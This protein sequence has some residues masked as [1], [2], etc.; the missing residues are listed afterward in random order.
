MRPFSRRARRLAVAG[1]GLAALAAGALPV[2]L[3]GHDHRPAAFDAKAAGSLTTSPEDNLAPGDPSIPDTSPAPTATTTTARPTTTTAR[4]TTTSSTTTTPTGAL[5]ACGPG[6]LKAQAWTDRAAYRPGDTVTVTAEL[7]NVSNRPCLFT[8]VDTTEPSAG[9]A[10]TVSFV[11]TI[12]TDTAHDVISL[13]T[14][15]PA[16]CGADPIALLPG[17]TLDRQVTGVFQP[18]S[19]CAGADGSGDCTLRS[20]QW[21]GSVSWSYV[22]PDG[23]T[24]TLLAKTSFTCADGACAPPP[25]VWPP[26]PSSTTTTSGSSTS[27]SST[28]SSSSTTTTTH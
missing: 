17:G 20:G 21:D 27:G 28:S 7:G 14:W 23:S 19:A 10:P 22:T 13:D 3:S 18:K 8:G 1:A 15:R 12:S 16:A 9:C 25:A 11:R 5:A 6:D 4:P 24:A 26:A 2:L